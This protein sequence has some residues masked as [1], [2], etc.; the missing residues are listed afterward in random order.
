[1]QAVPIFFGFAVCGFSSSRCVPH[2]KRKE[3]ARR[4][5][6]SA[7]LKGLILW[8]S[9]EYEICRRRNQHRNLTFSHHALQ[10]PT[11]IKPQCHDEIGT[12]PTFLGHISLHLPQFLPN[13]ACHGAS[14]CAAHLCLSTV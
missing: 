8:R 3:Y 5:V 7:R 12:R 13:L 6:F 4:V 10:I 11:D 9:G 14:K 1:M 2:G